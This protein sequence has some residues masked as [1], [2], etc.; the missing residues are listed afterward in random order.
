M[1][2]NQIV[3][4]NPEARLIDTLRRNGEKTLPRPSTQAK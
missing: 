2:A 4:R 1:T 3:G